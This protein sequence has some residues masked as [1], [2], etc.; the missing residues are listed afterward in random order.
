M[1]DVAGGNGNRNGNPLPIVSG[2]YAADTKLNAQHK[3][4]GQGV[5]QARRE[6]ISKNDFRKRLK[7]E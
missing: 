4:V 5:K 1:P 3:P 7:R 6:A 2:V